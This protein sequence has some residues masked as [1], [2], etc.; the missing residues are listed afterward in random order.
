MVPYKILCA[1]LS[2]II[3]GF[4]FSS[5]E[6]ESDDNDLLSVAIALS[7]CKDDGSPKLMLFN[8]GVHT[9]NL[10]GRAGADALCQASPNKPAAVSNVR[11]FISTGAADEIR[12][13]ADNYS[14]TKTIPVT[15]PNGCVQISNNIVDLMNHLIPR[16]ALSE[17]KVVPRGNNVY[18]WSGSYNDGDLGATSCTGFTSASGY[19]EAGSG[20]NIY[21]WFRIIQGDC[22]S[23][24]YLLCIGE[25]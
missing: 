12:D 5:C 20:Y 25:E 14:Y 19:G 21:Q 24:Y 13:L 8:A 23:S 17:A 10:G 7:S 4:F 9:G 11:A 1:V 6:D 16:V 15:G 3:S 22:G 2:V 18:W